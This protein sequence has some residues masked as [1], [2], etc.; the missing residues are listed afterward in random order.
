MQFVWLFMAV[1]SQSLQQTVEFSAASHLYK[2]LVSCLR[3]P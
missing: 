1:H 3:H 2:L